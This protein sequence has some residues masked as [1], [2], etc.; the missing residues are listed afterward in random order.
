MKQSKLILCMVICSYM[1][2]VLQRSQQKNKKQSRSTAPAKSF[3]ILLMIYC[4]WESMSLLSLGKNSCWSFILQ[5]ETI[6]FCFQCELKMSKYLSNAFNVK[7]I[8]RILWLFYY[9]I[10]FIWWDFMHINVEFI[11]I[12]WISSSSKYSWLL[13]LCVC[14]CIL[15]YVWQYI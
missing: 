9:F 5:N 13:C 11:F 8:D 15:N 10:L 4:S 14:V 2:C 6:V 7:I 3:D 1:F 12:W